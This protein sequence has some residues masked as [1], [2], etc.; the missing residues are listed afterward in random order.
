LIVDQ[1][2]TIDQT[3]TLTDI[4][5]NL[6]NQLRE[7][8]LELDSHADTCVLGRDALILLNFNRPVTVQ[9][10]D[11]AQGTAKYDVVSG[12]VSYTDSNTGE[13]YHL[14]ITKLFIFPI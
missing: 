8:T 11:P 7:T 3:R 5:S 12:V 6:D 14:V 10:Y 1:T 4:S 9:G 2:R 13:E